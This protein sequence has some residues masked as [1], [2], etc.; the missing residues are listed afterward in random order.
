MSAQ[1]T[2]LGTPVPEISEHGERRWLKPLSS[3]GI[4]TRLAFEQDYIARNTYTQPALAVDTTGPKITID[5]QDYFYVWESEPEPIG[6]GFWRITRR[7][8]RVPGEFE[9]L[10]SPYSATYPGIIIW[11][12]RWKRFCDRESGRIEDPNSPPDPPGEEEPPNCRWE[13]VLEPFKVREPITLSVESYVVHSFF[14]QLSPPAPLPAQSWRQPGG[15]WIIGP[16]GVIY[17]TDVFTQ[18]IYDQYLHAGAIL[19]PSQNPTVAEYK[20]WV[21]AGTR[22][23]A[24]TSEVERWMGNIW[25]RKTRYVVAR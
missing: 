16:G 18:W 21:T 23:I 6:G 11:Q 12:L 17:Q 24:E 20:S 4:E 5:G 7:Y 2:D 22:F 15:A 19:N 25:L 14:L 3:Y 13:L 1:W 10:E 8:A 9:V